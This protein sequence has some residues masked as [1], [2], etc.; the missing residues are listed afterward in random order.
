MSATWYGW[1]AVLK[2]RWGEVCSAK[3]T[4]VHIYTAGDFF[5][6]DALDIVGGGN[7]SPT[8]LVTTPSRTT[9]FILCR[10]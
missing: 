3:G 2:R 6:S 7:Y 10:I 8:A 9:Y 5:Q 1:N 4:V